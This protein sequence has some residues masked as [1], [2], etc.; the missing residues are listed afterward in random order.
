MNQLMV[1]IKE[2]RVSVLMCTCSLL[3]YT[4]TSPLLGRCT[5]LLESS[6]RKPLTQ[7]TFQCTHT[8]LLDRFSVVNGKYLYN[9]L[10]LF[11]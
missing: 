8:Y 4:S 2:E 1:A 10:F 5:E 9:V 11:S 3:A 7:L 6:K